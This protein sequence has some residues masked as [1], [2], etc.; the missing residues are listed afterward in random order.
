MFS[1]HGVI[2]CGDG[3]IIQNLTP[4]GI[5][6]NDFGYGGFSDACPKVAGGGEALHQ[7]HASAGASVRTLSRY[8]DRHVI[9]TL[10]H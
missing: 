3:V 9:K 7:A 2:K 6:I 8:F 5:I 4:Q 10:S 1:Q